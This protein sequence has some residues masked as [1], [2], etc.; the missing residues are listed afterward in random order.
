VAEA[1]RNVAVAGA[2]PW[3][4]TDCLNFGHPEDAEVMGDMDMTLAG[5]AS[6]ARAL[7]GLAQLGPR[8]RPG[9]GGPGTGGANHPLPF[10]SG[11][12]SL[13]NQVGPRA[14]PPSPIVMC[15]GVLRDV[16]RALGLGLR[17]AGHVLV[18]VGEPRD[19][20]EGSTYAREVLRERGGPPPPLDLAREARLQELAVGIA[21]G[22]WALA[23][24]DV[25]DG[26]L[27]VALVEMLLGSP[28]DGPL[29]ADLDLEPFEVDAPVS[30]YC[31]RPAIVHEVP[32]ERLARLSQAARELG[33]VAWPIG[34]VSQQPLLRVRMPGGETLMWTRAELA[35]ARDTGLRKLW[36]EEGQ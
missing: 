28:D 27:A 14:I 19:G 13:Y 5:L 33:F 4:L 25:S 10:V 32:F 36:N 24:H 6:A 12:V 26:G 17:A 1:A 7:G 29:G 11:N 34:T 8:P 16:S 22:G 15:A 18:L 9:A 2:R 3:A 21:E 31:E 20:L 23:A 35:Q 30:L